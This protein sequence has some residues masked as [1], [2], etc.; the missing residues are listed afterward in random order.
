M[1]TKEAARVE[2]FRVKKLP[3]VMVVELR[4]PDGKLWFRDHFFANDGEL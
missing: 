4:G 2:Y 1:P 3:E